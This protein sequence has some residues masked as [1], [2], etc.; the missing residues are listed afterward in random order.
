MIR[1]S[2]LVIALSLVRLL[3]AQQAF[4][5]QLSAY[6]NPASRPFYHGVA[7]GDPT[8]ESVII[9]TKVTPDH[10]GEIE[11]LWEM[12][13]DSLFSQVFKKDSV[14]TGP[15][16]NWTAHVDV[17]GLKPATYYYYR[18]AYDGKKSR[19][20]RTRTA[21]LGDVER[22]RFAVVSCSNYEAGFFNAYA[23]L[24]RRDDIEAVIHLGDYIYEYKTGKYGNKK[25]PRTNIPAHEIVKTDDYRARYS[26]YRL[27]PDLQDLHARHPFITIWDDHEIANDAYV[28][29]AQNHQPDEE[30]PWESRKAAAQKAYFEWLPV[31]RDDGGELY[32]SFRYGNLAEIWML[33]GRLAG[34][35]KQAQSAQDPAYASDTRTMLGQEQFEWLTQ[36]MAASDAVW[37]VIGNQVF[38]SSVDASKVF[39]TTPKFMDMWDGYPAERNRLFRFFESMQMNNI[40]VITGDSHTSWAFDLTRNPHN[41]SDYDAKTGKG[42]VGAEFCTPSV[43]SANY[44]EYVSRLAVKLGQRRFS[45][46]G[47]NPHAR[48]RDLTNH[49]YLIL[50][51]D[52]ESASAEWRHVRTVKSPTSKDRS[53]ATRVYR[54]GKGITKK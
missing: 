41:P 7:S 21:P 46:G 54:K 30:G 17:K 14:Q 48:Y 33:D 25:L 43:T 35:S 40:V 6:Y 19:I 53:A 47:I 26:Q 29:G 45:K 18:F 4:L 36:G 20:G 2:L 37:R 3:P 49:G 32:R 39:K 10:A 44:D 8:P 38:M 5:E 31:R 13:T 28:D 52:R 27:D 16:Q 42:V 23:N 50:T 12:A 11:V 24:A 34:R 9:W 15:D 1:L 22:L 51:L